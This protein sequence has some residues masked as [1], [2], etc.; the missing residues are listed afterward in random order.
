MGEAGRG[1][2]QGGRQGA[3]QAVLRG[4]GD[5]AV[6]IAFAFEAAVAVVKRRAVARGDAQGLQ[7]AVGG[8]VFDVLPAP[9]LLDTAASR[10]D[11]QSLRVADG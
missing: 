9:L 3:A 11:G 1:G 2:G 7:D 10:V 6:G 8:D 4:G 5:D